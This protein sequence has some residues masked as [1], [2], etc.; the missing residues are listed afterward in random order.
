MN[1]SEFSIDTPDG[2]QRA[3]QWVQN[4]INMLAPSGVWI[5]PRVHTI[6]SFDKEAKTYQHKIGPGDPD[7]DEVLRTMGWVKKEGQA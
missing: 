1:T 4:T 6:Y 3:Q 7:T 2:L 5:I